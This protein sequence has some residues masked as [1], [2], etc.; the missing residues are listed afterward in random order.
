MAMTVIFLTK[1]IRPISISFIVKF[2][3]F[4]FPPKI[5]FLLHSTFLSTYCSVPNQT[6]QSNATFLPVAFWSISRIFIFSIHTNLFCLY[7]E[8]RCIGIHSISA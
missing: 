8:I 1:I 7:S 5:S 3:I 2:G 6:T 4:Q